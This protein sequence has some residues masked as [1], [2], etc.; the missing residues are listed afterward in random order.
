MTNTRNTHAPTKRGAVVGFGETR[1]RDDTASHLTVSGHDQMPDAPLI[2]LTRADQVEC[3][4]VAWLWSEWLARGKLHILAG[5]PG[6]GKTTIAIAVA[7][8][9]SSGGFW[10]DGT[11]SQPG[12]VLL[13]SGEDSAADTLVPRLRA[14]GADLSRVLIVG[15]VP[16]DGLK[17]PFDPAR[18]VPAL[19]C[20]AQRLGGIVLLVADPVVSAIAGDS[21]KN[22][23]VRRALQPL[24]NLAER[25][26]AA[27]LGITH[28]S[29]GTAG[30]DPLERVTGSIAFGALARI[31]MVTAKQQ[32]AS[33]ELDNGEMRLLARAKSNIGPDGGGFAYRLAQATIHTSHG[34]M[35][36]SLVEWGDSLAGPARELLGAAEVDD[37]RDAGE[38]RDA[39]RWIQEML[40]FGPVCA[41]DIKR[42]SHA[43]GLSW[44]TV[45]RAMRKAG[46]ESSRS[47]FGKDAHYE[48][49]LVGHERQKLRCA[50]CAPFTD[51]GAHGAHALDDTGA[52]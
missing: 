22:T 32:A 46:A 11:R 35:E 12:N 48:W 50:P 42:D 14:A 9:V 27:V 26:G 18:D 2:E 7:A 13:W 4:P 8:V 44:R 3:R 43:A 38:S 37:T 31:V 20:E 52:T 15:D 39:V 41:K 47:G 24:V 6:T 5:A 40:R 51:P 17:R 1:P 25:L 36:A 21:H 34:D 29:K 30:R 45:Q 10:P 16:E 49:R 28:F 23:E 33:P 19:E